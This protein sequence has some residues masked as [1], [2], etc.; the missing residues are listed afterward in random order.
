MSTVDERDQI[1]CLSGHVPRFP[2]SG[3]VAACHILD[4]IFCTPVQRYDTD[5]K[6]WMR[7]DLH[8]IW[9]NRE[10]NIIGD[11]RV[12]WTRPINSNELAI[13]GMNQES[14][15]NPCLLT[16]GRIA[17]LNLREQH[18]GSFRIKSDLASAKEK[19]L[20]DAS[21]KRGLPFKQGDSNRR[22]T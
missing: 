1:C 19:E 16:K 5:N 2:S 15:L 14:R 10:F 7:S 12:I 4:Q 6:V 3:E 20:K 11:G 8:R 18:Y 9:D 21:K 17:Y 13:L 22:N